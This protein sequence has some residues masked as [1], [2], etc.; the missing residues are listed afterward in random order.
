MY[1][2][3]ITPEARPYLVLQKGALDHLKDDN[4]A[5]DA[6]YNQSMHNTMETIKPH[7]PDECAGVL[8]IGGG[9]GGIDIL[10]NKHFNGC[11]TFIIDGVQDKPEVVAHNKTF[12]DMMAARGFLRANDVREM[13]YLGPEDAQSDDSRMDIKFDLVVSFGAWCFHFPPSEY[14]DFVKAHC[15]L[16][17]V[18]ILDVRNEKRE[19]LEELVNAF[20][21]ATMIRETRKFTKWKF[22][23]AGR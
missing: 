13:A 4:A 9:M 19:W 6:A 1:E 18:I 21:P 11:V 2:F 10:I 22:V 3:K 12:N 20:G 8:D 15:K 16:G 23:Y 17:T 7:L 14:L 5:W